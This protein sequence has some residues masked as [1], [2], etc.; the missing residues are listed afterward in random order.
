MPK[1]P[2][3]LFKLCQYTTS[4]QLQFIR[5]TVQILYDF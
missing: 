2:V 3:M 4:R 5:G 1:D